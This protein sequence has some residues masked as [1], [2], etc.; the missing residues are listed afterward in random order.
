MNRKLLIL[1]GFVVVFVMFV[2]I[3]K[4]VLVFMSCSEYKD[5]YCVFFVIVD[6]MFRVVGVVV[7][8]ADVESKVWVKFYVEVEYRIFFVVGS[9]VAIWVVAQF[10]FLFV[11]FV[12]VV[13]IF[14]FIVEVI[15][16]KM[17][18]SKYDWLAYEFVK[19]FFVFFSFIVI[20]GVVLMFMFIILYPKFTNYLMS[21]FSSI[22]LLYVLLFFAEV[23]FFY[24]YM[25]GW[26][27]FHFLVYFGLGFGFNFVGMVIM[28]IV[29]VWFT[30]MMLLCGVLGM[31]VVISV[32]DAINNFIWMLINVYRVIVNVVFGGSVVAVYAVFKFFYAIFDEECAYYDWMGYIGNFVVISA[33][34]PFSFVG[35]WLAKEIYVYL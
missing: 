17:G 26:G 11:V 20:F 19:F 2:G 6:V 15:G 9:R 5:F 10:Y 12:L 30:F 7:E 28:F 14:A 29:N 31:G 23:F 4:I 1:F 22:F 33:F 8:K 18:D 3:V 24:I 27:K 34:F 21:V 25:Y 35:Y 32:L 13:L 16:Y